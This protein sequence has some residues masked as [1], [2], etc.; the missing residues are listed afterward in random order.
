MDVDVDV[1]APVTICHGVCPLMP[2]Q[3]MPFLKKQDRLEV[4]IYYS[5]MLKTYSYNIIKNII[6]S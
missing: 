3:R 4:K 1:T 2:F 5:K 6:I